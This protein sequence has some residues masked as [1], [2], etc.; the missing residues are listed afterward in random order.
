M[1][2]T[3]DRDGRVRSIAYDAIDRETET[4]T[5][6]GI[7]VNVLTFTYDQNSNLLT[8]ANNNGAYTTFSYDALGNRTLVQESFGGATT[9]PYNADVELTNR[10]FGENGLTSFST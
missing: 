8:A 4:W 7:T 10:Q 5:S 2:S 9:S 3:T 6:G 1:T